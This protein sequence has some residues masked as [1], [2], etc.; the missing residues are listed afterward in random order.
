[1]KQNQ[2]LSNFALIGLGRIGM[3]IL[4][5]LLDAS[6]VPITYD[7]NPK[8]LVKAK[9][10][11]AIIVESIAEV[12]NRSRLVYLSLPSPD[13]IDKVITGKGGL[14][15]TMQPGSRIVDLST[16]SPKFATRMANLCRE[17]KLHYL[18]SPVSGGLRGAENGTL[19]SVV[20]GRKC[21]IVAISE[22]MSIF[23]SKIIHGGP[24]GSGSACKLIHNMIGEVQV[25][26][27]ADALILGQKV[28]LD[29]RVLYSFLSHGMASSRV[30]TDLYFR[31]VSG[32]GSVIQA[33]VSSALREQELALEMACA[34]GF[35][36][37]FTPLVL[38]RLKALKVLGFG[39]ADVTSVYS[40]RIVT[41]D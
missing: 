38:E 31:I 36:L 5:R 3:R 26:V 40:S 30:L 12:A 2:K 41:S 11:G 27:I 34:S 29:P 14:M 32:K 33:T 6:T 39:D 28:G 20:G 21:D 19:T 37:T 1:M 13:V 7:I 10:S 8:L 15:E 16:T 9:R 25:H 4:K 17:R 35:D 22:T 23:C 18:D 24:T